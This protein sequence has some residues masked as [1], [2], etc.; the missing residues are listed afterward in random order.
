MK[1]ILG[2]GI[3]VVPLNDGRIVVNRILEGGSA[4][5]L[6]GIQSRDQIISANGHAISSVEM[7]LNIVRTSTDTVTLVVKPRIVKS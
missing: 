6:G 5:K 7:L 3:T 4:M 1:F 2:I